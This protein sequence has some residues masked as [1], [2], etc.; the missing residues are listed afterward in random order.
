ML[1]NMKSGYWLRGLFVALAA[2][3]LAYVVAEPRLAYAQQTDAAKERLAFDVTTVKPDDP[4]KMTMIELRV[5]PGGRLVI[6][7][8]SL[9]GL[10]ATA[11]DLPSWEVIG[12]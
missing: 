2:V 4:G 10:I 6:H 8:Y 3:S 12:G 11:F 1:V 7:G 9:R 5:Y